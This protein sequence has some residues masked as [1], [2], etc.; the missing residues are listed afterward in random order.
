VHRTPTRARWAL[1]CIGLLL[2]TLAQADDMA[3]A[4]KQY[5]AG[6]Y[7]EAIAT[8]EWVIDLDPT[9][10]RAYMYTALSHEKLEQWAEAKKYWEAYRTLVESA[11]EKATADNH[12][13]TCKAKLAPAGRKRSVSFAELSRASARIYT[14]RTERFIVHARNQKLA[15]LAAGYAE[16]YLTKLTERFMRGIAWPR[17]TTVEIY[18]DHKEYVLKSGMPAW[19]GGGFVYRPM[20][21]DNILRRVYLFQLDQNKRYLRDL[22]SE[23]LPH[24]LTHLVL[25]EY[26]GERQIPRALNEGLAMYMEEG[27]RAHKYDWKAYEAAKRNRHFKLVDLYGAF[28]YPKDPNRIWLFYSQSASVTRFMVDRLEPAQM[29]AAID[30]LK[31]GR[32]MQHALQRATGRPDNVLGSIGK[33]WREDILKNPPPKPKKQVKPKDLKKK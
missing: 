28:G 1:C 30:E 6:K 13:A 7:K 11:N 16:R 22:L 27:N 4:L 17:V 19:S 15:G 5:N 2:P 31:H 14:A 24:E 33:L 12:L 9:D 25:Q 29:A 10:T 18:R 32:P 23:I 20:G 21:V 26:F 3:N 8:L